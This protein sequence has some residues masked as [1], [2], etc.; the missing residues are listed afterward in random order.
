M[1][2]LVT[3]YMPY[4]DP[5][6]QLYVKPAYWSSAKVTL[7]QANEPHVSQ[8]TEPYN[9]D[10]HCDGHSKILILEHFACDLLFNCEFYNVDSTMWKLSTGNLKFSKSATI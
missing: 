5:G 3:E 7:R 4:Y 8:G 10:P 2:W 1:Q 9:C 6:L